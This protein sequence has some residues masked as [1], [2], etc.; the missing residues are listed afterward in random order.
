MVSFAESLLEI[1]AE[2]HLLWRQT[3]LIPG[4]AAAQMSDNTVVKWIVPSGG[5]RGH[6]APQWGIGDKQQT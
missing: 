1:L 4:R 5:T 2:K 6:K 3:Q